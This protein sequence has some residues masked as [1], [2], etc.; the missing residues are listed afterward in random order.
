MTSV[1]FISSQDINKNPI[2]ETMNWRGNGVCVCVHELALLTA[3]Y[4]TKAVALPGVRCSFVCLLYYLVHL[5]RLSEP[6]TV[7]LMR[8]RH[9][10]H[11]LYG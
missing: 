1:G 10:C 4:C 2:E 5:A 7:T 11:E 6:N 3:V 9:Q 8:G